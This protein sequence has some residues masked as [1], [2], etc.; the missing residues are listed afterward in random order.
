MVIINQTA[1]GLNLA[2]ISTEATTPGS[3]QMSDDG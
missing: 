2:H 1:L 3:L